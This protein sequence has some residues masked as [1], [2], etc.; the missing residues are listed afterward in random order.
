ME[1]A[2]NGVTVDLSGKLAERLG[3]ALDLAAVD[4]AAKSVAA[5]TND[6][7]VLQRPSEVQVVCAT[8]RR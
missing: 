3:V 2:P 4:G 6:R 8:P 1:Q 7:R 5:V